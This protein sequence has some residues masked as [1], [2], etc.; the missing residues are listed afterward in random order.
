MTKR[1]PSGV[2]FIY[3]E[4]STKDWVRVGS[5]TSLQL[6]G[7]GSETRSV[8][9]V[10][11]FFTPRSWSVRELRSRLLSTAKSITAIGARSTAVG[12]T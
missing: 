12:G 6:P 7:A 3:D 1:K 4:H 5:I 8:C 10:T 2:M 9:S 11:S